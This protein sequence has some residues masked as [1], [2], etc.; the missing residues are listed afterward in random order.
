[1]CDQDIGGYST[2]SLVH[3]PATRAQPGHAIFKGSISTRLPSDKPKI[4]RTGYA[5]WR[6]LDRKA[7]IFGKS[8]WDIDPY[9]YIALRVK[10]DGRKYFVNLMTEAVVPTDIHQHRI[11]A[12]KPGEWETILIDWNE[13]VRTNH[14]LV[15]QPAGEM[16][17]QKLKSIGIGLTD[18]APGPFEL[19]IERI[20]ATNGLQA[21]DYKEDSRPAGLSGFDKE[22]ADIIPQQPK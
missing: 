17:R 14:G 11:F 3:V 5:A 10:S 8:L 16:L 9:S 22:L 18:R 20:W 21:G 4:Q 15:V 6:T 7:T 12:R 1:M 2:A 13:F 19:A